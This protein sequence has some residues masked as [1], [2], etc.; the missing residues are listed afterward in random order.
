MPLLLIYTVGYPIFIII[1]LKRNQDKLEDDE[2]VSNYGF[3][4]IVY[5]PEMNYWEAIVMARKALIASVVVFSYDLGGN[6][7]GIL[8]CIILFVAFSLQIICMP[9]TSEHPKSHT[10]FL[11]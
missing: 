1:K 6:M 4:Y 7:Q 2:F 5:L 11:I 10:L 8:I 9:F 3:L